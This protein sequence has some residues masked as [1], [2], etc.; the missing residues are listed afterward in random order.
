M[1]IFISLLLLYTFNAVGQKID[2]I[3]FVDRHLDS[4]KAVTPSFDTS[5]Y[6]GIQFGTAR[7]DNEMYADEFVGQEHLIFVNYNRDERK[8]YHLIRGELKDAESGKI[9]LIPEDG[10][11]SKEVKEMLTQAH[12]QK[13]Y[14]LVE[15][16]DPDGEH[17]KQRSIFRILPA[18]TEKD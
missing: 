16:I 3:R 14:F 1:K 15:F 10:I 2:S 9:G 13:F 17:H 12:G 8:D 11:L 6:V 18:R 5:L 4:T 7:I